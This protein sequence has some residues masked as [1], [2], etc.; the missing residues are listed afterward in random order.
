LAPI[1]SQPNRWHQFQLLALIRCSL[2]HSQLN[3]LRYVSLS[4]LFYSLILI[5]TKK[6][7]MLFAVLNVNRWWG[8]HCLLPWWTLACCYHDSVCVWFDAN[9]HDSF[10]NSIIK[11]IRQLFFK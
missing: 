5:S 7:T 6:K 4:F 1:P 3:H 2:I 9:Y 11:C 8:C 10:A